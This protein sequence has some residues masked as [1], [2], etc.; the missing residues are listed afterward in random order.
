MNR[1]IVS[2]K[3]FFCEI[4]LIGLVGLTLAGC[5]KSEAK[6][7]S[8]DT[9][10]PPAQVEPDMD[11][12]NF[13]VDHPD[14]FPV[15]TAGAHVATSELNVTGTIS[16]DVSRQ[17]PAISTA[18]G[19]VT[20][21]YARVGDEVKEGQLLFKVSSTDI[22]AAFSDYKHAV[23]AEQLA[24]NQLVRAKILLDDGAIPKSQ[25]EI[26]QST[27]DAAQVD[28]E[29]TISRL[30]VLGADPA[31]PTDIVEMRAPVSGVI[32]D[33]QITNS[34]A[35]QAFGSPAPFTISDMSHVWIVLDVF[36]N[37]LSQVHMDE[38]AD[39]R[40]NAYP[41]RVLK[42]R[43]SNIGQILDPSLHTAKVRLEL[44]NPGIMRLGMFVTATFHGDSSGSR[45]TVPSSAVLH[46]HDRDFVYTPAADNHFRR[47][48]VTAGGMLPNNQ[49]EIV[50]GIKPGD[51]VVASALVLQSTV[52]Q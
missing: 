35:V 20:E 19:R 49:Q 16:A 24:K 30:R 40:L 27:E 28:V 2:N 18:T 44:T 10:P 41:D 32:T 52:E 37:T 22:A 26:A 8:G 15:V 39:V 3:V 51:K 7:D 12:S 45:A 25:L 29:T 6:A 13:K 33:Q 46:L 11:A 34:A 48:E 5:G 4:S 47:V 9:A 42:G 21:V 17:R 23:V 31:H 1:W 38:F 14:Q 36:E 50:S 43:I